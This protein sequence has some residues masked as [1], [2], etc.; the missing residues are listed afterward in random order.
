MRLEPNSELTWFITYEDGKVG[1]CGSK[2]CHKI[3]SM[4][5]D[6]V[7]IMLFY[8]GMNY[9]IRIITSSLNEIEL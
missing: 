2:L 6:T 7:S 3:R 4:P 5:Q 9:R 8:N 1:L